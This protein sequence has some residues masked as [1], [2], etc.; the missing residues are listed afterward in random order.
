MCFFF[1]NVCCVVHLFAS[2]IHP[3]AKRF[4]KEDKQNLAQMFTETIDGKEHYLA[5]AFIYGATIRGIDAGIVMPVW[6]ADGSHCKTARK[7][8]GMVRSEVPCYVSCLKY[9][10]PP[11]HVYCIINC[12]S[13]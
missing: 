9:T 11:R 3:F 7:G 6:G 8:G 10:S 2:L 4:V 5:S 12:L 1:D 13:P